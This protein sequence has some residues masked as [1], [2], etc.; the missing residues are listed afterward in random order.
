M[1]QR[2]AN[3]PYSGKQ[4]AWL[5]LSGYLSIAGTHQERQYFNND[6]SL[7]T[8]DVPAARLDITSMISPWVNAF[9]A[10]KWDT[11]KTN[12][13]SVNRAFMTIGNLNKTPFYMTLGTMFTPFG[14]YS[15]AMVTDPF[16]KN[17]GTYPHTP[18]CNFTWRQ[19]AQL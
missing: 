9:M 2:E 17:S 15:S 19:Q 16:D 1:R 18:R 5:Q 4:R 3:Q 14:R 12:N 7:S 8:L 11:T 6:K 10:L 13:L